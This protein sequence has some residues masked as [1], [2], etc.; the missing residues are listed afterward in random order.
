MVWELWQNGQ[1]VEITALGDKMILLLLGFIVL[2]ELVGR[3]FG[4]AEA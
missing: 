2:A 1:Y 4:I 3:R